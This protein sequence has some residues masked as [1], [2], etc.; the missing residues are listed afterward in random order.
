[1]ADRQTELRLMLRRLKLPAIAAL[2]EDLALKAA[3]ANLTHEAFLYELVRAECLQRDEHRTGHLQRISGL[4][5]DK[6]FGTL[7]MDRFPPIIREQLERLRSGAFLED[8]VNLEFAH[9][10]VEGVGTPR[11]WRRPSTW[12]VA[13]TASCVTRCISPSSGRSLGRPCSL[14]KQYSWST[15]RRLACSWSPSPTGSRNQSSSSALAPSTRRTVPRCRVGGRDPGRERRALHADLR[16]RS[17]RVRR[18]SDHL[19]IR[20][21]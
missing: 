11:R 3:K 1:M 18:P 5:P 9:F 20:H 17:Q 13:C 8:A 19:A 6:T 10:V 12:W 21:H 2:F 14:A 16:N 15:R 4:P 7:Q